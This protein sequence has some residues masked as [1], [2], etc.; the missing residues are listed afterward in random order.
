M[1]MFWY[2]KVK[3]GLNN[4]IDVPERYYEDVLTKLVADGLYDEEGNR[5]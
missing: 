5:L 1:V 2:V 4:L 3:L